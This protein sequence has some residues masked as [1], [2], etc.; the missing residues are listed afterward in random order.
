MR[1]KIT[2]LT[3]RAPFANLFPAQPDVLT[4]IKE[5][6]ETAGFDASKPLDVWRLN[7][8]L[9]VIDGHTRL[10]AAVGAGLTEVE[11]YLHD[12]PDE[13][14]ALEYAVRNQRNRR[15]LTGADL[16]RCVAALD[17]RK[18]HGAE[19]GGRGNQHTRANV[20]AE[21]LP[22][23]PTAEHTASVL[24]VSRA[25]VDRARAVL[26]GPAEVKQA[27][28]AGELSLR[29]AADKARTQKRETRQA[30]PK[31][32]ARCTFN[33]T[34]DNIE[35]APW[36]WNPVTGCLHGC[37]YCYA[38]DISNRFSGGFD[39]AFH[40][41]RL[42]A[43]KN[44]KLPAATGAARNVFVCS[45]ADL[46]GKWVPQD[47][48]DAVLEAVAAA[49]DWRFLFLTKNPSRLPTIDWPENAWV[50]ATVDEQ[51][52]VAPTVEAMAQVRAP[53][54]FLSCEPLRE[55][56]DFGADGLAAI[57]WLIVGGQSASS[58]EPAMQPEWE[59]VEDLVSQ[60][61]RDGLRVY[62]KPNLTVRPREYPVS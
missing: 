38:R 51:A 6:M 10:R 13:D 56:L 19:P 25:T 31:P 41:D 2:E 49:P 16:L 5:S 21:T 44:T 52:R 12:F 43:P 46:F 17:K 61:R 36:T 18:S 28:E 23:G 15:N 35:W 4:A 1:T 54:R 62:F 53:I 50:G 9:V 57:D 30:A 3:T 20:S 37:A 24:G 48:I 14:A 7:G 32:K 47:W 40:H 11:T 42:D 29:V 60:A 22:K 59:W 39:P 33:E 58:G 27:V 45:M 55:R 8:K 26:D 34:N